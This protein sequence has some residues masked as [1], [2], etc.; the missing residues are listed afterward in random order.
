MPL[1]LGHQRIVSSQ[2]ADEAV[3]FVQ[4]EAVELLGEDLRQGGAELLVGFAL[5]QLLEPPVVKYLLRDRDVVLVEAEEDGRLDNLPL[6]ML[7]DVI[8]VL[9]DPIVLALGED[10]IDG[11]LQPGSR[12]GRQV[13]G[14][15]LRGTSGPTGPRRLSSGRYS[16]ARRYTDCMGRCWRDSGQSIACR[17][18]ANSS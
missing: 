11:R 18:V 5:R 3:D 7:V 16:R 17:Y 10:P 13:R 6:P 1:V 14:G 15:G 4:R 12:G 2:P 8:G 9:A